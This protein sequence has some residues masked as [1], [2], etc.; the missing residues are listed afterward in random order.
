[1]MTGVF[2][3]DKQQITAG[4]VRRAK[5]NIICQRIQ[6]LLST[7][8]MSAAPSPAPQPLPPQQSSTRQKKQP[9]QMGIAA[10]AEDAKYQAK[11]KEL[12]R[13][14]KDIEQ[15]NEK[16]HFKVLQAKLNIR[17][18]KMERAILYERLSTVPPSPNL[19]DRHPLPPTHPVSGLPPPLQPPSR[20]VPPGHQ[21]REIRDHPSG[22]DLD[23]GPPHPPSEHVRSHGGSNSRHD[24]R[25]AQGMDPRPLP[26]HDNPVAVVG[27][28]AS[29]PHLHVHSPRRVP[30]GHEGNASRHAQQQQLPPMGQLPPVHQYEDSRGSSL[31]G[32]PPPQLHHP[33]SGGHS[34]NQSH[35]SPRSHSRSNQPQAESYR[36]GRGPPPGSGHSHHQYPESLPPVQQPLHSPSL[37]ERDRP[38]PRRS[39]HHHPHQLHPHE[40][41]SSHGDP[42]PYDRHQQPHPSTESSRA[43][44]S[45]SRMHPH[46][47]LG[48]GTYITRDD[49]PAHENN[50]AQKP[51]VQPQHRE[52]DLEREREWERERDRARDYSRGELYSPHRSRPPHI[53]SQTATGAG[54]HHVSGSNSASRTRA[55]G[56]P[57]PL[58]PSGPPS[59]GGAV[60]DRDAGQPYYPAEMHGSSRE[61]PRLSSRD[62]T[63][64]SGSASGSV[65]AGGTDTPSRPDSPRSQYYERDRTRN[66]SYRARTGIHP[67]DA[68]LPPPGHTPPPLAP[69]NTAGGGA[70]GGSGSN[71]DFS[72]LPEHQQRIPALESRKRSRNEMEVD[73]DDDVAGDGGSVGGREGGGGYGGAGSGGRLQPQDDRGSK[74]YHRETD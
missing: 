42:H 13:K 43:A 55:T 38:L 49:Y 48:P 67:N 4:T 39:E 14:V 61:Y 24:P 29:S 56:P 3:R 31:R 22:L 32:S 41:V 64:G 53:Q 65:G 54:E 71:T 25:M 17:R 63:P 34:R 5:V 21:Y 11:Y 26:A 10:G 27:G 47:R 45:S 51:H 40:Y 73:S 69:A 30:S 50:T 28:A 15:D 8:I 12:K 59:G 74:R 66:S 57:P 35:S 1:M 52:R 58:P 36:S 46:Q 2:G 44:V 19:Q 20:S 18:M 68:E 9:L 37:S 23:Q 60:D 70:P 6:C 62:D 33:S 72:S 7:S 16:L